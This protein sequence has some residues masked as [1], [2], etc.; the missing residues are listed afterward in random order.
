MRSARP[1]VLHELCGR[2]M[3]AYVLDAWD[4]AAGDAGLVP[5]PPVVVYSPTVAAITESFG[6]RATFA[7]Q[8]EPRGT[9]DA[10]RAG[11]A[12]LP[13]DAA[14]IL[15]LSGDV[16]LIS[17]ADL[18]SILEARRE[19]DAAIALATVFAADPAQLGRVIR[20]EFGIVEAIVE[21]K[22][23]TDEELDSNEVNAG[24]Y[25]FDGAWLRRRIATLAPS[26]TTGR[27]VPDRPHPT[28]A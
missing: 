23:A 16:P 15:V 4:G 8:D 20:S 21:A 3:L 7:L 12:S 22:D 18:T 5:A 14:E 10:V 25:A 26:P 6:D 27:A 19:D 11:L 2:P 1:K 24:L 28:R 9:G 17:A 13:E